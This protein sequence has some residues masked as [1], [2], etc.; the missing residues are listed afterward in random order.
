MYIYI[1]F[2]QYI[3]RKSIEYYIYIGRVAV[4]ILVVKSACCGVGRRAKRMLF[5]CI[6]KIDKVDKI[7]EIDKIKT[8]NSRDGAF[9]ASSTINLKGLGRFERLAV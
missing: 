1:S 9:Q 8:R 6:F 2:S 7:D 4:L 3:E 5:V